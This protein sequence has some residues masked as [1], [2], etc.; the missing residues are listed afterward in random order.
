MD[1]SD[2]ASLFAVC[3][4]G[5]CC[6]LELRA[7][8]DLPLPL[9][10]STLSD[11]PAGSNRT[12]DTRVRIGDRP[13]SWKAQRPAIDQSISELVITNAS[14]VVSTKKDEELQLL[15]ERLGKS[16]VEWPASLEDCRHVEHADTGAMCASGTKA[17]SR[18]SDSYAHGFGSQA[19]TH[20]NV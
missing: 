6:R 13:S 17:S 1:A 5:L 3:E 15:S 4:E 2:R 14:I 10:L 19:S 9:P 18:Q 11:P 12:G 20:Q 8:L 7:L 16:Q